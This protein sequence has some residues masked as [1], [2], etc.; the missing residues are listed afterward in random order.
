[1]LI[2]YTHHWAMTLKRIK[3]SPE[4]IFPQFLPSNSSLS[5]KT[6]QP[7]PL[8]LERR[9]AT[10]ACH[11][12]IFCNVASAPHTYTTQQ[13]LPAVH[14]SQGNFWTGPDR[15]TYMDHQCTFVGVVLVWLWDSG[16]LEQP[17][18]HCE[19]NEVTCGGC[20]LA[21]G[22]SATIR[23]LG[24]FFTHSQELTR[25]NLSH[26]HPEKP[27]W[28]AL[29]NFT[30]HEKIAYC[31]QYSLYFLKQIILCQVPCETKIRY[32]CPSFRNSLPWKGERHKS[33]SSPVIKAAKDVHTHAMKNTEGIG[34]TTG[35]RE[36]EGHAALG[37][38]AGA[39]AHLPWAQLY[40]LCGKAMAL[41]VFKHSLISLSTNG[42]EGTLGITRNSS[43]LW[44][45][46]LTPTCWNCKLRTQME[47][48][49]IQLTGYLRR[50]NKLHRCPPKWVTHKLHVPILQ[51]GTGAFP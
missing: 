44:P 38:H 19:E 29:R 15:D 35:C 41:Q 8:G 40:T 24:L 9:M 1:M 23:I 42:Q 28:Q 21:I 4:I 34:T 18:V 14:I 46:I 45:V 25:E 5:K 49:E 51:Y 6:S 50:A 47:A 36:T 16:E 48:E 17:N 22:W 33:F 43:H 7:Q 11:Q 26:L 31:I 20:L 27:R 30:W 13:F 10:V 2:T 12:L 3:G 37:S 39:W 32:P